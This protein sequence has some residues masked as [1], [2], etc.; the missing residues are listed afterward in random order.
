MD[1]YREKLM[2]MFGYDQGKTEARIET[3]QEQSRA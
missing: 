3:G 1:V 2:A